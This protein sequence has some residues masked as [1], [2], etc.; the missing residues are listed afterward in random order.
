MHWYKVKGDGAVEIHAQWELWCVGP[1]RFVDELVI[2]S[3][4]ACTS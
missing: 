1:S 3:E 2:M 4:A